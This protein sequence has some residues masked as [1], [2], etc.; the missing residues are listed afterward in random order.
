MSATNHTSVAPDLQLAP[1]NAS[2]FIGERRDER[3]TCGFAHLPGCYAPSLNET[4]CLC[5]EWRWTGQVGAWKSV[6]RRAYGDDIAPARGIGLCGVG[7]PGQAYVSLGWDTYFMHAPQ[8]K[9][10]DLSPCFPCCEGAES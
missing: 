10:H 3:L 9:H 5:G 6:E 7:H 1:E 2:A 4:F 8:C